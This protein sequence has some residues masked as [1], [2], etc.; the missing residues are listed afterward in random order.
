MSDGELTG[1]T[2]RCSCGREASWDEPG[3]P[4]PIARAN[5]PE[6]GAALLFSSFVKMDVA[7]TEQCNFSCLMCR[8]SPDDAATLG[9]DEVFR[10]MEQAREIG[11]KVIS[12]CG[13]EPFMHPYF[14][15]IAERAIELGFKVQLTTNGSLVTAEHLERLRGLDCITLSIDALEATHDRIRGVEGAFAGAVRTLKLAGEA[16]I[17]CGTNTVIQKL[18]ASELLP[19]FQGLLEA[20]GG[21][22]DYV[23]HAPVEVTPELAHLMLEGDEVELVQ[24]Q[25]QRIAEICDERDIYFSHPKQLLEHLP[26]FLDKWTRHRPLGGCR[27]PGKFIG[28]SHLGFYLCWHQGQSIRAPNL[29]EALESDVARQVIAEALDGRWVPPAIQRA[30]RVVSAGRARGRL[31]SH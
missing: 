18:N 15:E 4:Q 9:R 5:C 8:R 14:L 16:G 13:G 24:V 28:Y 29:V 27:I 6:C 1:A 19:L 20:T 25:L 17:T 12:F 10:V 3:S 7:L 31:S 26:L 30:D 21:K 23:R 2:K 11:L 22:I